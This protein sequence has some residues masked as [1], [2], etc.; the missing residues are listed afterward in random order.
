MRSALLTLLV[1]ALA[2]GGAAHARSDATAA[3]LVLA[4][5]P[6]PAEVPLH[7]DVASS[8]TV[9]NESGAKISR[10]MVSA[11]FSGTRA[12]FRSVTATPQ[13]TCQIR[14]GKE[15]LV[16]RLGALKP[17]VAVTVSITGAASLGGDLLTTVALGAGDAGLDAP[18][19]LREAT[20]RVTESTAPAGVAITGYDLT[21]QFQLDQRLK[22][23]WTGADLD[24]GIAGFDVRVQE[25]HAGRPFE[26]HRMW[27][28]ATT[29]K[30]ALFQAK[31]GRTYCFSVR[32]A[33]RLGNVSAWSADR[34]TAVPV[35]IK[36]LKRSAGWQVVRNDGYFGSHYA[37]TKLRGASLALPAVAGRTIALVATRCPGCGAVDVL[38]NGRL[39]KRVNLN[40]KFSARRVLVRVAKFASVRRGTVLVRV[41]T[42]KARVK[43]EGIGVTTV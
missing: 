6:P 28:Q 20:T 30:K 8:V 2:A 7:G 27:L 26:P 22:I 23:E 16:C 39:L 3:G 36:Q 34:C 35:G 10:V 15:R 31:P 25:A 38:F 19:E 11:A 41:A 37:K 32:A 21:Q 29:E 40:A 1:A 14:E 42:Q 13:G 33:D 18:L 5:Q 4:F 9:K 24:S 43:I 12:E 17:G